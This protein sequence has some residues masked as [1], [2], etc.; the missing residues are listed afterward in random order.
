NNTVR[1][2]ISPVGIVSMF[3]TLIN[4]R[5]NRPG[6]VAAWFAT[7]PLEEDR[8][9][10][11]QALISRVPAASLR[12]LNR[13]SSNYNTFKARLRSLPPPPAPRRTR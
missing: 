8:I 13:N 11:A 5:K 3:Q 6:G 9:A 10:N 4:E 12:G 7:H 2:R 1:A